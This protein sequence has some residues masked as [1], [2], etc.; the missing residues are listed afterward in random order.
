MRFGATRSIAKGE[1][2]SLFFEPTETPKLTIRWDDSGDRDVTVTL[3]AE[4]RETIDVVALV[5]SAGEDGV[6][7]IAV[8]PRQAEEVD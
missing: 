1:G 4:Q 5:R 3:P 7:F 8:A 2:E 6:D